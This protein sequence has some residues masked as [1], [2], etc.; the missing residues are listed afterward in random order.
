M[1]KDK[2]ME[3]VVEEIA[4]DIAQIRGLPAWWVLPD[5][6]TKEC[7]CACKEACKREAGMLLKTKFNSTSIY[8]ILSMYAR[9][10]LV[11]ITPEE[12]K[13]I[14]YQ[15]KARKTES[16]NNSRGIIAKLKPIAERSK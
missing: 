12:A 2:D 7:G 10:E 16:F 1:T 6:Q 15:F 4:I 8:D 9:G 5:K 3:K 13:N 11:R 14:I